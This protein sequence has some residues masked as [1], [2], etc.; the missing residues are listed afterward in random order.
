[1]SYYRKKCI[2]L[3]KIAFLALFLNCKIENGIL[4]NFF[5]IILCSN[6]F[7]KLLEIG[8]KLLKNP[9]LILQFTKKAEKAILRSRIQTFL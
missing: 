8:E 1:M 7:S 6:L 9:F 4:S 3:Q 5:P 2:L